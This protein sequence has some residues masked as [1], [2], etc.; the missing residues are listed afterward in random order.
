MIRVHRAHVAAL[1]FGMAVLSDP[2]EHAL[3]RYRVEQ[4][5]RLETT[6]AQVQPVPGRLRTEPVTTVVEGRVRFVLER[7]PAENSMGDGPVLAPAG[8]GIWRFSQVEVEGP[9]TEPPG[10][11]D[12]GV[13]QALADGLAAVQQLEGQEFHGDVAELPV[14]PLGEASPPW[15]T[16]WLRWAQSGSF[17]GVK[18]DPVELA[19]RADSHATP[20][21]YEVRW[22]RTD[23]RQAACH[24]QQARWAVPVQP[25]PGSVP[26]VLA[27][28]GVEARTH[29]AA[30]SLEWVTQSN[31]V[32]VYAERSAVRETF[33]S[34][35]KVKKPELR[36]LMFRLRLIV[37]VRLERLP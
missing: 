21:S 27:A 13:E 9:R 7:G 2:A 29:F 37:Q 19:T 11:T 8:G 4:V 25:A 36:E 20:A 33:W 16:G 3:A 24:V 32:L 35:E 28:E 17:A 31:P 26:A 5:F 22:L 6:S 14:L 23:F 18:A 10:A 12:P 30:L 34:L 1:L 15:L